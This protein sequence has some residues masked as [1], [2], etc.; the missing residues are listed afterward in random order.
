MNS[1]LRRGSTLRYLHGDHLGS[2]VLV[3]DPN[4]AAVAHYRYEDFGRLRWSSGQEAGNLD[5]R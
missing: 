4:G 2:I 1:A 3:T 5:R